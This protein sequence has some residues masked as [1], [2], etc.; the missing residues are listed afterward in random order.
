M[1]RWVIT[2]I[3]MIHISCPT[4]STKII[5][6]LAVTLILRF[7][8]KV[9]ENFRILESKYFLELLLCFWYFKH[10]I[11]YMKRENKWACTLKKKIRLH[12]LRLRFLKLPMTC[13]KAP[14]FIFLFL[15][16]PQRNVGPNGLIDFSMIKVAFGEQTAGLGVFLDIIQEN[17]DFVLSFKFLTIF[18][19][20]F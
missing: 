20:I 4:S 10:Y 11:T 15:I 3:L 18:I 16:C 12:F 8:R 9:L 17:S 19:W 13:W 7:I 2:T 5:L 6:S 1:R 14:F